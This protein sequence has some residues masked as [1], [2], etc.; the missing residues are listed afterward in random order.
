[1]EGKAISFGSTS[2][3]F[4]QQKLSTP[5]NILVQPNGKIVVV[6]IE[7]YKY[8]LTRFDLSGKLDKTFGTNGQTDTGLFSAVL[9]YQRSAMMADGRVVVITNVG[10]TVEL[11]RFT[12]DGALDTTFASGGILTNTSMLYGLIFAVYPDGRIR[13]RLPGIPPP[14]MWASPCTRSRTGA[15]AAQ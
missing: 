15:S 5:S 8:T 10:W 7:N 9:D 1:M 12:A 11:R 13:A 14:V 3:G 2:E 4:S 6:S